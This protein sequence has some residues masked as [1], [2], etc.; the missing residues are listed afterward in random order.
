MKAKP[1]ISTPV[2]RSELDYYYDPEDDFDEIG[3]LCA[4]SLMRLFGRRRWPIALRLHAWA[5]PGRGRKAIRLRRVQRRGWSDHTMD[6]RWTSSA[7][8]RPRAWFELEFSEW[9]RANAPFADRLRAGETVT[10]YVELEI[11]EAAK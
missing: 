3:V 4:K 11:V 9:I 2:M 6:V 7:T 5:S 1:I 8:S 10:L